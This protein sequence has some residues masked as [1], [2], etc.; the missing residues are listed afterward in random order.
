[1][2]IQYVA[3]VASGVHSGVAK[4]EADTLLSYIRNGAQ[5]R[6]DGSG[7]VHLDL[8]PLG[9]DIDDASFRHRPDGIDP[10]LI[11]LLAAAKVLVESPSIQKLEECIQRELH[12]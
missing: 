9:A 10:L 3:N 1:M 4:N 11:E 5:L 2:V 8:F 12:P 7:G 6:K